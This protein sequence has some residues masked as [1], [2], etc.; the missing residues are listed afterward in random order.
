MAS[1]K[2]PFVEELLTEEI[3]N[4]LGSRGPGPVSPEAQ[5]WGAPDVHSK[6]GSQL[7]ADGLSRPLPQA[8]R[9]EDPGV[10][11]S[12]TE[13][14]PN[15]QPALTLAMPGPAHVTP[16]LPH[17]VPPALVSKARPR[18]HQQA[19]LSGHFQPRSL[20]CPKPTRTLGPVAD[21]GA[22]TSCGSREQTS[23]PWK[24]WGPRW[25]L[26]CHRRYHSPHAP[27]ADTSL[28]SPRLPHN[29]CGE[30]EDWVGCSGVRRPMV[31]V[32]R[33]TLG[34]A[35]APRAQ[36]TSP[37]PTGASYP[38][39]EALRGLWGGRRGTTTAHTQGWAHSRCW[40]PQ[41][42]QDGT[43]AAPHRHRPH[44][45]RLL[46]SY[47]GS[48]DAHVSEPQYAW[49]TLGAAQTRRTALLNVWVLPG[50]QEHPDCRTDPGTATQSST[51][52]GTSLGSCT[53]LGSGS[54]YWSH[55][56]KWTAVW[57]PLPHLDHL[58]GYRVL[59]RQRRKLPPP[60]T[61]G[62]AGRQAAAGQAA[63]GD[64]SRGSPRGT[65]SSRPQS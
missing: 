27:R 65:A 39:Q 22:H 19:G 64:N 33:P 4:A 46:E 37:R 50:S 53:V 34:R 42:A 26:P 35:E 61:P 36:L 57:A 10:L 11:A 3:P 49:D 32:L 47:R 15:T 45:A 62:A 14:H 52:M 51:A 17:S 58:A 59:G 24:D 12:R 48:L 40:R 60:R 6:N 44:G 43:L 16:A 41:R 21:T 1:L 28:S 18:G 13:S 30:A 2:H 7:R 5:S 55:R 25:P 20:W 31:Q 8:G 29:P 54:V 38:Q 9:R 63:S 56:R 23:P